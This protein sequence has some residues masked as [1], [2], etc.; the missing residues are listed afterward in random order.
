MSAG[1]ATENVLVDLAKET[2]G[3]SLPLDALLE[4]GTYICNWSGHLLR[5]SDTDPDGNRFATL[6]HTVSEPWTVTRISADP[7][8][9]R[10]KAKALAGSFGLSVNF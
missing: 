4:P 2:V 1:I 7:H 9:S 5:V 6:R 3:V 10:F 8:I